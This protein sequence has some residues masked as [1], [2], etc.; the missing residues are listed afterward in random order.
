VQVVYSDTESA[1]RDAAFQERRLLGVE[2]P[3]WV[4]I[5]SIGMSLYI[6]LIDVFG[7]ILSVMVIVS[8]GPRF[9]WLSYSNSSLNTGKRTRARVVRALRDDAAFLR[10]LMV[11]LLCPSGDVFASAFEVSIRDD[12]PETKQGCSGRSS[13]QRRNPARRFRIDW[14]RI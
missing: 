13:C 7:S 11:A 4:E 8:N 6:C 1:T 5:V 3:T 12:L 14:Q 10:A 9:L 2:G